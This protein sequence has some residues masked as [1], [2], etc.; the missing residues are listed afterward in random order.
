M[1]SANEA[2]DL[3][4]LRC[5][6]MLHRERHLSRAATRAGVSQPAMSRALGRLRETFDDAL[7]VRTPKGMLPT[8]RADELA[9]R[10]AALLDAAD[11]LLKSDRLDPSRLAR[12]FVI[13]TSGFL[14]AHL[15][16]R[17]IT[18][19]AREA[20]GVSVTT[21]PL[22]HDVGEA[23]ATGRFDLMLGVRE[24]VPEGLLQTRLYEERYVCAVRRDHPIVRSDQLTLETYISLPH[25]LVAPGGYPGSH[26]DKALAARGLARRV[27]VKVHTFPTAP[28]IVASSD[29][30]LTAP[31]RVIE[32]LAGPLGLR[33]LPPP[34]DLDRFPVFAAWH[35]RAHDDHAHRWFRAQVCAASRE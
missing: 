18:T 28:A 27:V 26:V 13:A 2:P 12:G 32:P 9:P 22:G 19:L 17:L 20:P 6:A 21:R 23:L 11:A 24:S 31:A 1:R 15:L 10:V 14:D 4:L 34:L 7:F 16:P 33:L 29:M 30:V 3:D 25:L 8:A 35:P 5:F